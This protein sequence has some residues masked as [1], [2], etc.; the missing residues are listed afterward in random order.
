MGCWNYKIIWVG[1]ITSCWILLHTNWILL[2]RFD[3]KFL[4]LILCLCKRKIFS[5]FIRK[6]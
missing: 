2:S 4:D 6:N 3:V 1:G 5:Y